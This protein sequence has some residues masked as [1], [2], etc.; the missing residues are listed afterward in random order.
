MSKIFGGSKTKSQQSSQQTSQNLA[1]PAINQAFMPG[2]TSAFQAGTGALQNEL[3]GGYDAYKANTGFD[4][5]SK[6]GLQKTAGGYSGRGLFNSGATMKALSDYQ[7]QIGSA[8]YNDYLQQQAALAGLGLQG[9]NLVGSAGN[10]SQGTSQGTSSTKT[11]PGL[12]GL[13]GS[14]MSS[15]A[16]GPGGAFAN[17]FGRK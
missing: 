14:I 7:Q 17:L 13:V 11:S 8:S 2:A 3:A 10:Y 15:A 16:L 12:T 4:F 9:G 6:L 1:Y 5:W